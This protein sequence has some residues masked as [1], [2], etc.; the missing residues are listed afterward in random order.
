MK[1]NE[2]HKKAV[3]LSE[4]YNYKPCCV[5]KNCLTGYNAEL[6]LGE[7]NTIHQDDIVET[8]TARPEGQKGKP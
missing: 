6:W 2:A 8:I 1:L 7:N 4:Y 5:I 3:W